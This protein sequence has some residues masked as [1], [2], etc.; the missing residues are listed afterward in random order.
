MRKTDRSM[1]PGTP[2]PNWRIDLEQAPPSGGPYELVGRTRFHVT[3]P[4]TGCRLHSWSGT[5]EASFHGSWVREGRSGVA[6]AWI[7]REGRFAVARFEDG[8]EERLPL[9]DALPSGAGRERLKDGANRQAEGRPCS[10]CGGR[11]EISRAREM[12]RAQT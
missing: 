11:R 12:L 7:H 10:A 8:R 3:E 1:R 2:L 4:A 6:D 5:S 9:P